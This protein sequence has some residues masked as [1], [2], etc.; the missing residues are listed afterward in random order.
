MACSV[1][2]SG[3]PSRGRIY[4]AKALHLHLG[5][6]SICS[7]CSVVLIVMGGHQ[8]MTHLSFK[9]SPSMVK[10][11]IREVQFTT[12][13]NKENHSIPSNIPCVQV[14]TK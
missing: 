12:G 7:N 5:S 13:E 2:Y 1:A 10:V 3:A 14:G 8:G 6:L 9:D 4:T 11:T